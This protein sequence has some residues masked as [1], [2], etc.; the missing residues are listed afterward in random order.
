MFQDPH[1]LYLVAQQRHEEL[2]AELEMIQKF[3]SSQ[4]PVK[5]KN[6]LLGCIMLPIGDLFI[7]IGVGLK[8]RFGSMPEGTEDMV[9]DVFE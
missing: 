8:R 3:K 2:L 9:I 7:A 6:K 4:R 1:M 5:K